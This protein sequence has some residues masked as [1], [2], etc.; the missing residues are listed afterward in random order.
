MPVDKVQNPMVRAPE[1]E[2][3]EHVIGV[4]DEVAIGEKEQLYQ[5][6]S[7]LPRARLACRPLQTAGWPA[8]GRRDIYV[9]HVDIFDADCYSFARIH[10]TIVPKRP[11]CRAE[12]RL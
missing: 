5:I 6:V 12:N 1:L 10:E 8:L 11:Y 2:P 9:S 3:F 4:A 7:R